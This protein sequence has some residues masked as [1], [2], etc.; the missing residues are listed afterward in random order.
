MKLRKYKI[1]LIF[2]FNYL[3]MYYFGKFFEFFIIM[4]LSEYFLLFKCFF[5][6]KSLKKVG[7]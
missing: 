7:I 2:K 5:L 4:F 3:I 6:I 1:Y